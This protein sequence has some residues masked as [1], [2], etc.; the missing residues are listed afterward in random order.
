M[1]SETLILLIYVILLGAYTYGV[2][3]SAKYL[4]PTEQQMEINDLNIRLENLN[5]QILKK[6]VEIE[7]LNRRQELDSLINQNKDE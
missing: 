1:K 2:W 3:Q 6:N 5:W 4:I 7:T